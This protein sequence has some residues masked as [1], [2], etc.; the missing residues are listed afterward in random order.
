M[1]FGGVRIPTTAR[2]ACIL[3]DLESNYTKTIQ[4]I[5]DRYISEERGEE[6]PP[7][8]QIHPAE[9]SIEVD[10]RTAGADR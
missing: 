1:G 8:S 4:M 2:R 5:R 10:A 3:C 9:I 7:R 6:R